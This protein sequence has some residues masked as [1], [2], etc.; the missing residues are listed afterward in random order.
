M[1]E[2]ITYK[3]CSL[4]VWAGIE[5]GCWDINNWFEL[6]SFEHPSITTNSEI[7]D[8]LIELGYISAG[9]KYHDV[10]FEDIGN[11]IRIC[12]KSRDNLPVYDLIEQYQC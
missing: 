2:T 6:G 1:E 7:L 4:D 5:E 12:D 10:E 3:I 9:I 11:G 8:H